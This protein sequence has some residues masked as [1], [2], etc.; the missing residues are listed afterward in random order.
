MVLGAVIVRLPIEGE[1]SVQTAPTTLGVLMDTLCI[2]PLVMVAQPPIKMDEKTS[3]CQ[4]MQ[5]APPMSTAPHPAALL[6]RPQ[7]DCLLYSLHTRGLK[8]IAEASAG[9]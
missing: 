6:S 5:Y 4:R 2:E 8:Y 1:D 3:A 7:M 9:L